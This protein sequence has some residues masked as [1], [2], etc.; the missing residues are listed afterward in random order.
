MGVNFRLFLGCL[1]GVAACGSPPAKDTKYPPR[2][3]GCD[4]G[5]FVEIPPMPTD[6]IGPVMATCDDSVTD[7]ECMRTL[8]DQACKLGADVVWG[9]SDVPAREGGKK[10]ISGRAAHKKAAGN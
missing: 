9:V 6:N 3:E 8:K 4:V 5:I 2:P 10:K 1:L 7:G